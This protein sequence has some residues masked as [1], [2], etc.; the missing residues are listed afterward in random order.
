MAA[1][2]T[3]D[4]FLAN[5]N[6]LSQTNLLPPIILAGE[7][8]T[9]I[10]SAIMGLIG[11]AKLLQA[12]ARDRL[13][14]GLSIFGQGTRGA[15]EPIYAILLTYAL[16]QLALFADLNQIAAL[17]SMGYQV[18]SCL[19]SPFSLLPRKYVDMVRPSR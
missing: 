2:T 16:T 12:L 10:F 3:R 18:R 7:C 19:P 11:S 6:V 5:E 4:T 8:A 17:I 15:D 13:V 14:P 9:T 1:S